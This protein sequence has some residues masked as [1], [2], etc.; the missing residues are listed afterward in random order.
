LRLNSQTLPGWVRGPLAVLVVLVAFC[1]AGR[2]KTQGQPV[3]V[4]NSAP[5]DSLTSDRQL[6][7]WTTLAGG[8][9]FA[10]LFGALLLVFTRRTAPAE[11]TAD[12]AHE[13]AEEQRRSAEALLASEERYQMLAEQ[14]SDFIARH[15]MDG[16]L[17]Y[18]SSTCRSLLG[19]EPEEMVGM[20]YFEL[21]DPADVDPVREQIR[22][23]ADAGQGIATMCCRVQ[24]NDG[25][26]VWLESRLR[27]LNDPLTQAPSEVL[28]TSRDI[29]ERKRVEAMRKELVAMLSHDLKN[30]L[31][32]VLGFAE[33]LRDLPPD[34][35]QRDEFLGRIEAN[36]QAALSLAVN[37]VDA[38]EIEDGA[39]AARLEPVL[40]NEAIEHAVRRQ[41][42]RARVKQIR[43]E[44]RLDDSEPMALLDP[45]LFDRVI[46]NLVDNAIKFSPTNGSVSVETA[47]HDG[48]VVVRVQDQGPGIPEDQRPKLFRRFTEMRSRRPDSSGL[49]LFIVKTL[50]D[51][52]R[53][54][55]GATFPTE[56]GTI[57]EIA[58][59][60]GSG[61]PASDD[62]GFPA[63]HP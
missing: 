42:S 61:S 49:G 38:L 29:S 31:A 41:A 1:V 8:V 36:A 32:A 28:T 47:L 57:F 5:A 14:S 22:A 55:V 35:P 37:F 60:A 48:A 11:R 15:R 58:F 52:Q 2:L 6:Q 3:G 25:R 16:V 9:T 62:V 63:D 43:L 53:G 56:G 51:A 50:V 46:A 4:A 19:Y 40:L 26:Y 39:V 10:A 7:T 59:P 20:S 27:V 23:V 45:R 18:A 17:T 13:A 44:T 30:P 12:P 34:E 21:L 54:T 24:R 33:I